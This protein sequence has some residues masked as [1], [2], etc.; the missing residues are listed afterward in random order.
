MIKTENLS[1]IFWDKSKGD[2]FAVKNVNLEINKGEIFGLLGPNGAGKTTLLRMLIGIIKP[3]EGEIYYNGVPLKGNEE[4]IKNKVS[5]LSE[6]TKLYEKLSIDEILNYMGKLYEIPESL[7]ADKK[8]EL[9]TA[10]DMHDFK[11]KAIGKLS[12]GQKQKSSIARVMI[13]NPDI[14]ILDEPTLGL[15]VIT[16]RNIIEFI[17]NEAKNGKTIIFSSHYMEEVESLCDRICLFHK[18]RV[19][20]VGTLAEF[21]EKDYGNNLREIFLNHIDKLEGERYE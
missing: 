3:T 11:D 16:S 8:Y 6:N 7:L 18:G 1:K 13:N 21:K 19:L 15:D 4:Y 12:T 2:F 20:D 10:F 9:Y 5:F 17:K 14:Y